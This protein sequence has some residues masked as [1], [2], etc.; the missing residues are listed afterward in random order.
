MTADQLA[1]RP[2]ICG[3]DGS[4]ASLAAARLAHSLALV[5]ETPVQYLYVA[6]P[7]P[8][9]EGVRK[10]RIVHGRLADAVG[11]GAPLRVL[12]GTPAQRL[13]EIAREA[14]MVVL[15]TRGRTAV[16]H[17]LG[18]STSTAVARAATAPVLVVP[19]QPAGV[20]RMPERG[21]AL[22]CGVRDSSD[23]PCAATSA[24]LARELELRLVLLHVVPPPRLPV[25]PAGGA[26][27]P[28]LLLSPEEQVAG[29]SRML[30]DIACAIAPCAP[31]VC[32]TLTVRG[33]PGRELRR[34]AAS[35]DAVLV[36]LGPSRHRGPWS[37]LGRRSARSLLRGGKQ[38]VLLPPTPESV[39]GG[40]QPATTTRPTDVTS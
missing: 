7:G 21:R 30:D 13:V 32:R 37:A 6:R 38:P 31:T 8:E 26:P 33:R 35:E 5:W 14:S 12:A 17:A 39:F 4:D 3:V 22:I 25:A 9:V 27:P 36:A 20:P 15:G 23:L 10:L 18:G 11:R 16:R 1:T 28:G 19:A 40:A 29:A 34:I 2:I 24:W